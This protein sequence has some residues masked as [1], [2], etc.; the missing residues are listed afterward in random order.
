VKLELQADCFAGVWARHATTD[1]S[2]GGGPP[3]VSD[4]S[5][6]DVDSA[7]TVAG[8]IGDDWIQKNLGGGQVNQNTFTH[9]SSKQ[10]QKW[11]GIGIQ[12]G[13]PTKCDTFA[14]GVDLG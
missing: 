14:H 1:P 5:Q 7:L 10:R 3:I 4:I 9:G 8:R 6:S 13:D 12:S 2:P 11:F